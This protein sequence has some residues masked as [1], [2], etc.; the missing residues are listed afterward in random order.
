MRLPLTRPNLFEKG[1]SCMLC[2]LTPRNVTKCTRGVKKTDYGASISSPE[3][4]RRASGAMAHSHCLKQE[5]LQPQPYSIASCPTK[6]SALWGSILSG[7]RPL[8]PPQMHFYHHSMQTSYSHHSICK[9][10]NILLLF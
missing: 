2:Y 5:T 7:T 3:F 9:R 8:P 1:Q 10:G 6:P 4:S